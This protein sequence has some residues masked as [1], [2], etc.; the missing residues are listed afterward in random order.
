MAKL[1][2]EYGKTLRLSY[3]VIVS[4]CGVAITDN[5]ISKL[6]SPETELYNPLSSELIQQ[7]TPH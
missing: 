5:E 1:K 3:N 2:S 4:G 7:F 6:I